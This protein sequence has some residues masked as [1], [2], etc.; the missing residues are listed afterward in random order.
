[1]TDPK[2]DR[3]RRLERPRADGP[4]GEP[5]SPGT[6]TRIEA[7]EGP[8]AAAPPADGGGEGPPA[9][10]GDLERFRAPAERPL[11][12]DLPGEDAQPFLRCASCETDNFRTAARCSS[13]GADLDTEP[14]REFNRRFWAG[15]KAEAAAEAE[16]LA[17]RQSARDAE[18]ID[19]G[20][21]RRQA[22]ESLAREVGAAE[23]RRLEREGFGPGWTGPDLEDLIV[24]DGRPATPL[25]FRLLRSLPPGWAVPVGLA[26]L[27]LPVGLYLVW[28][29]AGLATGAG[30]VIFCLPPR[31]RSW[32]ETWFNR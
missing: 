14:Q 9:S 23:R 6:D 27:A 3:F 7:V 2:Y 21:L 32:F 11:E 12:L 29:L 5:R 25:A 4:A 8:D 24:G 19:E 30:L 20:A 15:R 13:C 10:G 26:S 22:G 31:R 17:A 16:V 28:P 1:V 18:R